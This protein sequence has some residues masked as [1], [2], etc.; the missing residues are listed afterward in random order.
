[1]ANIYYIRVDNILEGRRLFLL[2]SL[3]FEA[4]NRVRIFIIIPLMS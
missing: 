4:L 1:M 3:T 2:S